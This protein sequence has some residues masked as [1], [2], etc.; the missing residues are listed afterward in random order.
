LQFRTPFD[1]ELLITKE[2]KAGVGRQIIPKVTAAYPC[3]QEAE[4][5]GPSPTKNITWT[6]LKRGTTGIPHQ[7][8]ASVLEYHEKLAFIQV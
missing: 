4:S 5:P 3:V 1:H 2:D 8:A 7:G 6:A